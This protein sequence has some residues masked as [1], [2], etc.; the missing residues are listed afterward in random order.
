[1][2]QLAT[3]S[4][5]SEMLKKLLET[6][7]ETEHQRWLVP[8]TQISLTDETLILGAPNDFSRNYVRDHYL[9]FIGDAAKA[10]LKKDLEIK[11][12]TILSDADQERKT[13]DSSAKEDLTTQDEDAALSQTSL[14]SAEHTS[15]A[16][17]YTKNNLFDPVRPGDFSSLKEKYTFEN[18]VRGTSNRTAYEAA[19]AV[20]KNPGQVYNPLFL[21]GGVGLG[22]THLMHAI[23]NRILKDNP[24]MRVL[25]ISS[26]KFLNDFIASIRD[27][28]P[29]DFQN[30][31]RNI[32]VLLVDDIQFLYT[33]ERT[34]E[35]FFH[36]FNVLYDADKAIILSADRHPR[37][38]KN[39]EDRL[40]SRFE[41]GLPV[42]ITAP[43][44]ETRIAILQKKAMMENLDIQE[45]VFYFIASRVDSNVREL[46]GALTRVVLQASIDKKPIT[47]EIASRAMH[48]SYPTERTKE[49]TL[50]LIQDVTASY[51]NITTED[52]LSKKRSQDVAFPRQVAMYLCC[53][54]TETSTTKIGEYFGGKDH[55][56]VMHARDKIAKKREQDSHFNQKIG[57]LIDRIRQM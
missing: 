45:D 4:I 12:E 46:E 5:W 31:Y 18:F 34:Q 8:M 19:L 41:W 6:T 7:T 25:Y 10:V 37:D 38:I 42:D 1:M 3:Q 35:E 11:I 51:F 14:F 27:G 53:T 16:P 33:K 29:A 23:G 24:T 22:K 55:S 17:S 39:L 43:D 30:K 9:P 47:V 50:E 28:K 48:G 49:I 56:T 54:M 57:E 15:T 20:A 52:L 44:L 40:R 13:K 26:E 21:Y 2:E 36:T 32:D